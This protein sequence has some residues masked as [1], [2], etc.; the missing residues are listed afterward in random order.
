MKKYIYTLVVVASFSAVGFGQEKAEPDS[1]SFIDFDFNKNFGIYEIAKRF[2]DPAVARMALYNLLFITDNQVAILDSLAVNYF[3]SR[4]YISSA[5]VAQENVELNSRNELAL[6]IGAIS[7]N[8]IGAKTKALEFYE[9]LALINDKVQTHFQVAQ[10]QFELG[11]LNEAQ[12]TAEF[13]SKKTGIEEAKLV[14]PKVDKSNQNVSM[15]AAI[16]NLQGLIAEKQEDAN[17]AT[18]LFL[19]SLQEEP[20]FEVAQ[21]NIKRIKEAKKK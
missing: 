11:R 7:F 6:E 14:Y 10:L 13:L 1:T 16:Y 17:K 4:N 3:S 18:E 2:N 12:T 9:D 20:S 21:L 5:L 19:K 15:K 8:N